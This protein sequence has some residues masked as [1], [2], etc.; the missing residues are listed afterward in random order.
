MAH[1]YLG[2]VM[3]TE[4][5]NMDE[6]YSAWYPVHSRHLLDRCC[7]LPTPSSTSFSVKGKASRPKG[8]SSCP[9]LFCI[10][11]PKEA[12][13]VL[14]PR[15]DV[16]QGRWTCSP[17]ERQECR[18]HPCRSQAAPLCC[19]CSHS[20]G[21]LLLQGP[22]PAPTQLPVHPSLSVGASDQV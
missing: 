22:I 6:N 17:G 14:L 3:G 7:Y 1:P 15:V 13:R 4:H 20:H 11:C 8:T 10:L 12:H 21:P 16:F 18:H 5:S 2:Q 9:S 19:L